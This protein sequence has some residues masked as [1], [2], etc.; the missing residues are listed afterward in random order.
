MDET[1]IKAGRKARGKMRQGQLWPIYGENDEVVFRY[2]DSWKHAHVREILG[3]RFRGTLL[4]DG[5]DGYAR[6]AEMMDGVTHA[7]CWAH[8][9][10]PFESALDAEPEAA[11][12]ALKS[13]LA[14]TR[15]SALS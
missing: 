4:S 9:R 13:D 8:T 10:R 7:N 2:T 12:Q 3:D 14:R 6:Y 1:P 5:Y 11:G 15:D